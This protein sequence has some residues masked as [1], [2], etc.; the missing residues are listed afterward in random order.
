[1]YRPEKDENK[2]GEGRQMESKFEIGDIVKLKNYDLK[3]K[4]REKCKRD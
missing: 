4:C 2:M 1:M 3:K